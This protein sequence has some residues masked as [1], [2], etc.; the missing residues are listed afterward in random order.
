MSGF[1]YFLDT[2]IFLRIVAKD[3]KLKLAQCE[4]LIKAIAE[5]RM[6]AATSSLVVAEVIWTCLCGYGLTAGET[7]DIL[8]SIL[9]I[10]NLK[11][12]ERTKIFS[13]AEFYTRHNI[14][15]ADCLIASHPDIV[16]GKT[17]IVSYDRDFDKLGIKRLEPAE[18]V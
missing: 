5:R 2:N 12:V 8:S 15:F 11:F 18:V 14:K 9:S 10:K 7:R 16:S 13:A 1:K 17:T 4:K 3:D 6:S